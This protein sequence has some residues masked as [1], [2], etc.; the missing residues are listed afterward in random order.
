[1][2]VYVLRTVKRVIEHKVQILFTM[3]RKTVLNL[4][5]AVIQHFHDLFKLS[6]GSK[7]PGRNGASYR[8][9]KFISHTNITTTIIFRVHSAHDSV[10]VR[11][12]PAALEIR[13]T[14]PIS[15][16]DLDIVFPSDQIIAPALENL[17]LTL[18][19]NGDIAS[20][21]YSE[22]VLTGLN[23]TNNPPM[24][25]EA[26]GYAG[27]APDNAISIK[28]ISVNLTHLVIEISIKNDYSK[29]GGVL[30]AKFSSDTEGIIRGLLHGVSVHVLSSDQLA[31]V[32]PDE[33]GVFPMRRITIVYPPDQ[34]LM[35]AAMG[36]PRPDVSIIK[37]YSDNTKAEVPSETI[38][39]DDYTFIKTFTLTA[40][41]PQYMEGKYLCRQVC[42]IILIYYSKI[43]KRINIIQQHSVHCN[44]KLPIFITEYC[45][46]W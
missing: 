34:S 25:F 7:R 41:N 38:I 45:L 27:Q 13:G 3:S 23:T 35:C 29:F 31:T 1:M 28:P 33:I 21:A 16:L 17:T 14:Y 8:S 22:I 37:I 36:N 26:F 18:T 46:V 24:V 12:D 44:S 2:H 20:I 4:I 30:S 10:G 5:S 39:R 6:E 43:C 32:P 40:D 42:I 15:P 11:L 19:I 9:E